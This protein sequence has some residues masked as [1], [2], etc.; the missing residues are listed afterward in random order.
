MNAVLLDLQAPMVSSDPL[1][2]LDRWVGLEPMDLM[3]LSDPPDN[4][5]SMDE[6]AVMENPVFLDLRVKWDHLDQWVLP[7]HLELRDLVDLRDPKENV[8]IRDVMDPRVCAARL[9]TKVP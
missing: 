3:A 2:L 1:V 9:A 8:A 5:V 7:V 6:W 4:L